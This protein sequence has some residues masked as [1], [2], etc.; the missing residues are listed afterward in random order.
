MTYPPALVV[1]EGIDGSGTTTQ[2]RRLC[3]WI[4]RVRGESTH[5]TFEP[6]DGP[7]GKLIRRVLR[8]QDT[9]NDS[10]LALAFAADRCDHIAREILP[11]LQSETWVVSDRY[12]YSSLAY[13]SITKPLSWVRNVNRFVHPANLTIYLR[14]SS[15]VA[16]R[17][18]AKRGNNPELFEATDVQRRIVE[19][20][21]HLLGSDPTCG[22]WVQSEN[23][24]I[25][26]QSPQQQGPPMAGELAI[27]DGEQ[28]ADEVHKQI[29][30][31]ICAFAK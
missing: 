28:G 29:T 21:D 8:G 15:E 14:V 16:A 25:V 11:M 2:A 19:Q 1:L 9:L 4:Q 17:R 12:L 31:L 18:R 6:S 10:A 23:R 27:I 13:Q 26:Q 3:D 24:W 20:Y 30:E 22:H 7:V 5:L